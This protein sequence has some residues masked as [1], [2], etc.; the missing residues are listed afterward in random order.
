MIL[1]IVLLSVLLIVS[2]GLNFYFGIKLSKV[3]D[4]V[5]DEQKFINKITDDIQYTYK[6][7][8]IIDDRQ[9]FEKDDDVGVV[10]SNIVQ[11]IEDLNNKYD[12]KN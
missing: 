2:I 8:K 11:I 4:L 6:Q 9:M 12:K 7:L 1:T 10:F 5:E 3:I